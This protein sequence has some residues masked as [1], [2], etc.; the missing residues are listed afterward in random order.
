MVLMKKVSSKEVLEI[1]ADLVRESIPND[2]EGN[3]HLR[4]DDD[5]N[6]EIFFI[7]KTESMAQ[8]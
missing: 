6:I 1:I 2:K 4:Y 3:L 5:D 7:E 8:A